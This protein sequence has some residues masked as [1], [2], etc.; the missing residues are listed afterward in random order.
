MNFVN[1]LLLIAGL[2]CLAI[3][4]LVHL[5]RRRQPK[6]VVFSTLRLMQPSQK[7]NEEKEADHRLAPFSP[8]VS[9]HHFSRCRIFEILSRRLVRWSPTPKGGDRADRRS[10]RLD[11]CSR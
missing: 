9:R 2:A 8:P 10:L 11:E 7:D 6:R 4:V 3:P 5:Q 1:P